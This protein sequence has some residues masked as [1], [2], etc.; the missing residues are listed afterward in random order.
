M[1]V[2]HDISEILPTLKAR[3]PESVKLN[4]LF[5]KSEFIKEA[6]Y[7]IEFTLAVALFLVIFVIFL[8]LGKAFDTFIPV[9]AL[10]MSII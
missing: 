6:V 2:I 10:P 1:S 5:D 3:L 9:L 7:D 4:T 8:Y